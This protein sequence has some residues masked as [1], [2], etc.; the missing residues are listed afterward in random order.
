[1][2]IKIGINGFGRIG[3][4]S[5]RAGLQRKGFD[6]LAIN[7][8]D[9]TPAQVA[10]LFKYDSVHGRFEGDVDYDDKAIIV[11]GKRVEILDCRDPK[12]LNWG[13]LGVEYVLE[14]TGKFLTRETASVHLERGA[15]VVVLSAP[16]K[17]DTP[18]FV[19]GVNHN[20]YRPEMDIV[21]NASCT[22][23]CLAPMAKIIHDN[24]GIEEGLMTTIHAVTASESAV[25]SF[26]KKN[27][28]LGRSVLDNIIPTTTGA[29]KAVGRVIPEL[30][31]KLTGT[32]VRVPVSNVSLVDLTVRLS[33]DAKYSEICRVMKEAAEGE[34]AGIV[35]YVDEDVVS[36]DFL[37]DARTCIF[38]ANA[39]LSL[40]DRFVKLMAW[41]DNEWGY[42]N[43]LLDLVTHIHK[44]RNAGVETITGVSPSTLRKLV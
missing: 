41:Y 11:N 36:S 32:S 27:W 13:D 17:D 10:Y 21:S 16:S 33:K 24:F 40:S 6:I 2:G 22:T 34:Y 3:R 19:M 44:V 42:S 7:A 37:T 39:G 35:G 18:I 28:R 5:F 8:P 23:N 26:N 29:A 12:K 14:C 15:K 31:G 25:D 43:K 30:E 20:K 38:D 4:L 1:M 9:K